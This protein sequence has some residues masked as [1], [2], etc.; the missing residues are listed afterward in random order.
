MP[1]S[2]FRRL[3]ALAPLLAV[4]LLSAEPVAAQPGGASTA[5][6]VD[7]FRR[8][9]ERCWADAPGSPGARPDVAVELNLRLAADGTITEVTAAGNDRLS[10]P[11]HRAAAQSAVNAVRTCRQHLH[12]PQERY[13]EWSLLSLRIRADSADPA[14]TPTFQ[15]PDSLLRQSL[16]LNGRSVRLEAVLDCSMAA[17]KGPACRAWCEPLGLRVPVEIGRLDAKM[18]AALLSTCRGGASSGCRSAILGDLRKL[19]RGAL[20]DA[21][22]VFPAG[23]GEPALQD[24]TEPRPPPEGMVRRPP[25]ALDDP[26]LL[27]CQEGAWILSRTRAS[28][29]ANGG[30][31][32]E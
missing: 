28:C 21:Q 8:G 27:V 31:V 1:R 6:A 15:C 11:L 24:R 9:L 20:L 10:D 3:A 5:V 16:P 13:H 29:E 18:Q 17:E 32:L 22:A 30:R 23:A 7:A 26:E 14:A 19:P 25:S 4:S 2:P 12:A